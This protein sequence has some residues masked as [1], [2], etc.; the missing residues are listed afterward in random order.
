MVKPI[1]VIMFVILS[2]FVLA[3]EDDPQVIDLG[4]YKQ[5]SKIEIK[6]SCINSDELCS[7]GASCNL[8]VS[9]PNT[10]YMVFDQVMTQNK[11]FYNYTLPDSSTL[12]IHSMSIY[13]IDG[14]D[15]ILSNY[16]FLIS[17][18]GD[19][20]SALFIYIVELLMKVGFF[21][22]LIVISVLGIRK[23][24]KA[25]NTPYRMVALLRTMW[26]A[27][28]YA[29]LFT[30]P[31]IALFLFHPN[32]NISILRVVTLRTYIV[33]F[34]VATPIILF[35]I[36]YF[37]GNLLLKWG[38]LHHDSDRT[39]KVLNDLSKFSVDTV[40]FRNKIRNKLFKGK[41]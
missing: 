34:A 38:G 27:A 6:V 30:S 9:Y 18:T 21:V 10:S 16:E 24:K 8:T 28:S 32:F 39:N 12:G 14:T 40:S 33:I 31:I 4:T 41:Q 26:A 20:S 3:A 2:C 11:S 36:F 13:C 5:N 7:V 23:L 37:S 17:E 25:E 22:Y 35:N 29:L 1:Y 15:S 19:K